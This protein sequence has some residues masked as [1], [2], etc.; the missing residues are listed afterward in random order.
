MSKATWYGCK[1]VEASAPNNVD[2]KLNK[3]VENV[4]AEYEKAKMKERLASAYLSDIGTPKEAGR[5]IYL[6]MVTGSGQQP[7][8]ALRRV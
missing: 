7:K 6:Q 3:V 1:T 8:T 5:R 2:G 4:F